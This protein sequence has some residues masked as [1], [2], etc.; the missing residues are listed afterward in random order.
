M[1]AVSRARAVLAATRGPQRPEQFIPTWDPTTYKPK[2][3]HSIHDL[4]VNNSYL[5]A[6]AA[7]LD[8]ATSHRTH[9]SCGRAGDAIPQ[10]G[11]VAPSSPPSLS[12]ILGILG[13]LGILA[14]LVIARHPRHCSPSL[15]LPPTGLN[16][17]RQA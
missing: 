9:R 10:D 2:H 5:Y 17:P 8:L 15:L 13:I 12:V 3:F 4:G 16:L 1:D 11:E 7:P 14:I 6:C